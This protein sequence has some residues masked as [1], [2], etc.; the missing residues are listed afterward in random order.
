M[1]LLNIGCGGFSVRRETA[2]VILKGHFGCWVGCWAARS[3]VSPAELHG[4]TLQLCVVPAS[5]LVFDAGQRPQLQVYSP[6]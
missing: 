4:V 2:I 6:R 3:P 5:C 1:V